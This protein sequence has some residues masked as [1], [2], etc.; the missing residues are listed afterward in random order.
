M[1]HVEINIGKHTDIRSKGIPNTLNLF[2][3]PMQKIR[4]KDWY[5]MRLV[6]E[7]CDYAQK[8]EGLYWEIEKKHD[9][10]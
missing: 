10:S 2:L 4:I 6:R 3:I 7:Y 1:K 8:N 5:I 9:L